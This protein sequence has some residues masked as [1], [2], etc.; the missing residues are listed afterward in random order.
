M[1]EQLIEMERATIAAFKAKND[2]AFTKFF[3]KNYVGIANDG[4][5][6]PAD[7]VS[8]MHELDLREVEVVAETV[9][10]PTPDVGI[11]TYTMKV[12]ADAGGKSVAGNIYASTVYAREGGA[13]RAVLHTESMAT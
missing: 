10:F 1:R 6:T 3:S 2:E 7:E 11:L 4:M 12:K 13:W 9:S 8:G 5:K